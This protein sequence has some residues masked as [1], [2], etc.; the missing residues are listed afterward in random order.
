MPNVPASCCCSIVSKWCCSAGWCAWAWP[1]G[2]WPPTWATA[3]D[4]LGLPG[5][6][7]GVLVRLFDVRRHL[8]EVLG[9][10]RRL[11][12]PLEA[13]RAPRIRPRDLA[14]LERPEEVDD[15]QQVAEA[16]DTGARRRHHVQHL[17]LVGIHVVAARHAHVAEDELREEREVEADEHQDGADARPE[18]RVHAPGDLGPPEV[19]AG[20]VADD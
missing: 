19:Q 15:R 6:V 9:Q 1:W 16:E 5:G 10:R 13:R 8:D 14:V 20:Q 4:K 17:E 2:P 18:L 3:S 7:R 11:R 12:A